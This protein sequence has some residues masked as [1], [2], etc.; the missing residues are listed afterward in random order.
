M[1]AIRGVASQNTSKTTPTV[2]RESSNAVLMCESAD[3]SDASA[4]SPRGPQPGD[5]GMPI[6]VAAAAPSARAGRHETQELPKS[7][8]LQS[9]V[10]RVPSDIASP[11]GKQGTPPPSNRRRSTPCAPLSAAL[12]ASFDVE[13]V[14]D[15]PAPRRSGPASLSQPQRSRGSR[16]KH[17][18][19]DMF[20][21]QRE[22][23]IEAADSDSS[24]STAAFQA[25]YEE[26]MEAEAR[27]RARGG[28]RKPLVARPRQPRGQP[29]A[30]PLD[31]GSELAD[32]PTQ[33]AQ[34]EPQTAQDGPHTRHSAISELQTPEAS[35]ETDWDS[36]DAAASPNIAGEGK[37]AAPRCSRPL[38]S[39]PRPQPAGTRP[40]VPLTGGRAL[41]QKARRGSGRPLP[42]GPRVLASHVQPPGSGGGGKESDEAP[43]AGKPAEED[44]LESSWD[45]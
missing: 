3:A 5:R 1:R 40:L 38:P 20:T 6:L 12:S 39:A 9:P 35:S 19:Q 43:D 26:R 42:P 41:L 4:H 24:E 34:A 37:E 22:L 30:L 32:P 33:Q 23:I 14:Q 15:S 13:E 44:F 10:L 25:T 18:E 17:F 7:P 27:T 2:R 21:S 36:W 28:L 16:A 8:T 45:A 31:V 29:H 11:S